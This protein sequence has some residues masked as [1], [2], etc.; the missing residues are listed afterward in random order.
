MRKM[1]ETS[2]DEKMLKGEKLSFSV[3]MDKEFQTIRDDYVCLRI[4]RKD[5]T[6]RTEIC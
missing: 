4:L 6:G 3:T 1:I 5:C 2:G